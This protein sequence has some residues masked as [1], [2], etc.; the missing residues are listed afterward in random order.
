MYHPL[1]VPLVLQGAGGDFADQ[2]ENCRCPEGAEPNVSERAGKTRRKRYAGARM[3]NGFA[4]GIAIISKITAHQQIQTGDEIGLEQHINVY[5]LAAE[6]AGALETPPISWQATKA[7][8]AIQFE[9]RF[10]LLLTNHQHWFKHDIPD[11]S[12]L[13]QQLSHFLL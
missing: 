5:V 2:R 12:G 8:M 10:I 6:F 11:R 1:L 4:I 7:Q 9:D 13:A 3:V